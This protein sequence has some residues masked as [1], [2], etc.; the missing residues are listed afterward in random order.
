MSFIVLEFSS[1]LTGAVEPFELAP[2]M[3]L[4]VDP[5]ALVLYA[6]RPSV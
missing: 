5:L 6:I 4:V 2:S 1:V 3:L